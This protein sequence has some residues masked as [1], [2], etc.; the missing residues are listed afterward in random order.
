MILLTEVDI[1][2][3]AFFIT[4]GD[5]VA[6]VLFFDLFDDFA[7]HELAELC[8]VYLAAAAKHTLHFLDFIYFK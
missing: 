8:V 6:E 7:G 1:T 2:K 4:A 5:V 3:C